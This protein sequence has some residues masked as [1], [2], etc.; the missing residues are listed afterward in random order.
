[1]TLIYVLIERVVAESYLEERLNVGFVD[2]H[3]ADVDELQQGREHLGTDVGVPIDPDCGEGGIV[4][5]ERVNVAREGADDHF[6]HREDVG[7]AA[8]LDEIVLRKYIEFW[9]GMF[10]YYLQICV[11]LGAES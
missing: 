6:V 1:M 9:F 3:L 11:P 10:E 5:A 7:P 8:N 2:R 4:G